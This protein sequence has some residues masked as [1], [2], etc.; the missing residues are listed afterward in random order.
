MIV[1]LGNPGSKYEKTRHN[2]GFMAID[3]LARRKNVTF[4]EERNFQA[5]V[6]DYFENG[7]KIYLV[8]PTTFMNLS[9]KAV[10]PLVT[11]FN[12]PFENLIILH[13]DL[14]SPAGRIRLRAKGGSGG[15]NGLK[16]IIDHLNTK[17]FQ[18]IKI[19]IGRPEKNTSVVNHVLGKIAENERVEME[20]ALQKAVDAVEYF[21]AGAD[22]LDTMNQYNKQ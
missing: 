6:G 21:V 1:G 14:D 5:L 3:E 16:S 11:Y 8:K 4:K 15:Q 18:R 12:V 2:I 17:E 7:E 20:I 10:A 19:G 13:D 22:F 9:G